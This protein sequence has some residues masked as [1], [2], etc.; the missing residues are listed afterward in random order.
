LFS[1]AVSPMYPT[2]VD[3]II[4]PEQTLPILG[5]LRVIASPGHTPGHVSFYAPQHKL[6]IAGD[7]LNAI[8]GKLKFVDGSMTWNYERGMQSVR[9]QAALKPEIV[10]VGH[11]PMLQG[12]QLVFPMSA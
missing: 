2:Q 11:G 9:E 10:V 12:A 7:S 1:K 4:E 5:G 8:G 3:E 6:L